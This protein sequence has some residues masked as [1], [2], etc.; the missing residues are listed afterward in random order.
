MSGSDTQEYHVDASSLAFSQERERDMVDLSAVH[1][2]DVASLKVLCVDDDQVNILIISRLL[3][4]LGIQAH[5]LRTLGDG[6]EVEPFLEKGDFEPDLILLDIIMR[7]VNGDVVRRELLFV[8]LCS[9]RMY[10]TI[11]SCIV[12]VNS[13]I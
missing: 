7:R 12:K 13:R 10:P 11:F 5:N 4:R 8:C 6:D 2:K 1:P 3:T 9:I